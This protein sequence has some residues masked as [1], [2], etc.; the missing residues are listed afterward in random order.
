[1]KGSAAVAGGGIAGLCAAAYLRARGW[2]VTV[3]ERADRLPATGT[4]L[5]MWPSAVRALD[6]IGV[7]GRVRSLGVE[8][9]HAEIRRPDGRVVAGGDTRGAAYLLSRPALL[10]ALAEVVPGDATVFGT[11]APAIADLSAADVIIGA[12]GLRSPTRRQLFGA[13]HEPRYVGRTAWRG[14]VP[15]HRDGVVETWDTD[16]LFGLTPRD[17]GLINWFASVRTAPGNDEGL[18]G[19]RSRFGSWHPEIREVL[20]AATAETTLQ[21]DLYESPPLPSYVRDNVALVGDAAHAMAPNLGHGACEAI[22]DGVT[23]GRLLVAGP[24]VRTALRRYDRRRRMPTR[25]LVRASRLAADVAMAGRGRRSRDRV[26]RTLTA[27]T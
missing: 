18:A 17:G 14:W 27:L 22:V 6:E 12:D 20:A 3:F 9:H 26:L 8:Q 4:A 24:D 25:L 1:M 11:P 5:G 21:H 10:A 7:G 2:D 19:V 16:A 13:G 15:G 23:L